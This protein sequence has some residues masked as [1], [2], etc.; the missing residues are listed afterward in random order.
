[1]TISQTYFVTGKVRNGVEIDNCLIFV[2]EK[3]P[4]AR[5]QKKGQQSWPQTD[6]K[7]LT[8]TTGACITKKI[9]P[10]INLLIFG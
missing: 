4:L 10:K 3:Q 7:P 6:D 1:M 9:T 5:R 8:S 2:E